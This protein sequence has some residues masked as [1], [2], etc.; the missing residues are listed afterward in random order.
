MDFKE[1]VIDFIKTVPKGTVVSYGQ[2][3]V[4]CGKNRGARE[5]GWILRHADMSKDQVPWWRVVNQKGE[6]S[7]KGNWTASK[8]LQVELLRKEGIKLE[9]NFTINIKKYRYGK[10]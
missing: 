2:V 4:A 10:L 9:K 7:I 6:I 3:A 8:E 5:V 1:S